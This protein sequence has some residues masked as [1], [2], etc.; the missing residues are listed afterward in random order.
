M[1]IVD[2]HYCNLHLQRWKP[3]ILLLLGWDCVW[4]KQG[5]CVKPL[6][7]YLIQWKLSIANML[8]SGHLFISGYLFRK[9]VSTVDRVHLVIHLGKAG[10]LKIIKACPTFVWYEIR[11][12]IKR[13]HLK[14]SEFRVLL[15]VAFMTSCGTQW[16]SSTKLYTLS[17]WNWTEIFSKIVN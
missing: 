16:K 14:K 15:F 17:V 12:L 7:S 5:D 1:T 2:S 3:N 9:Q 11:D 10:W 6:Q 8:H 13:V 4:S